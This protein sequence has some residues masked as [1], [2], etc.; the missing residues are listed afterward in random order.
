MTDITVRPM[1]AAD[2]ERVLAIYQAG[3]DGGNASFETAAPNWATFDA[4]KLAEHRFVAVDAD[5]IV[6]GWIAVSPT[7]TRAVYAGVVEHSVY[8]DPAAQGRGVARLLLD[9]LI[10]STEAAGIWTIQSGI[11]PENVASL[12]LHDKAGFRTIGTRERVGRHHGRWRDVVL[13]ERR[14][15]AID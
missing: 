11:F 5:D 14:S 3:L 2:A 15:P 10:A 12:A 4:A 8:V 13:L 7:S 6:I 1:R 9:A